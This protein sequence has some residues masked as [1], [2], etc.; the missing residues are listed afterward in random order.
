ME[1]IKVLWVTGVTRDASPIAKAVNKANSK[2]EKSPAAINN[3]FLCSLGT[4]R[5]G[6]S[7]L[8]SRISKISIPPI[9]KLRDAEKAGW[10][11]TD[12][13]LINSSPKEMQMVLKNA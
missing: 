10:T 5:A 9:V 7:P 1:K 8:I 4:R 3:S 11:S 6:C 13:I 2:T 12:A